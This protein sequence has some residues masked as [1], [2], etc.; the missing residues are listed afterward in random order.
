MWS[1]VN[2]LHTLIIHGRFI[3][4]NEEFYLFNIY[5]PCDALARKHLWDSLS[6]RLQQL[7][8]KK[9]FVCEDFNV[10]RCR[11]ERRSTTGHL[12]SDFTLFNEFI[13][14]NF[15]F[16]LPSGGRMFTLFKEDGKS[17]S[18]LD[19]FLLS[20]EWCLLW[21]NCLQIAQLR[22]LSDHCPLILSVDEENWAPT[23]EV[24]E[25]LERYS[26]V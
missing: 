7:R 1:S 13:D 23:N 6:P 21:S 4:S 17:M 24:V 9:V 15:L 19:W 11:E 25:V 8:G 3:K 2:C 12:I 22:G 26:R 20:E 16:D 18:R 14:S 5:A 10:V